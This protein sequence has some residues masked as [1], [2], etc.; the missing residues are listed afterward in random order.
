MDENVSVPLRSFPSNSQAPLSSPSSL[1]PSLPLCDPPTTPISILP[2]YVGRWFGSFI[3]VLVRVARSPP[4]AALLC[5]GCPAPVPRRF[6][7]PAIGHCVHLALIFVLDY[8]LNNP[9]TLTKYKTAAQISEKVLADVSKL[10]VA[11]AKIVDLCEQGDKLIEEELAKV[12]RG[13]K[14]TKGV[15]YLGSCRNR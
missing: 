5:P 9:D 6:P 8:S 1:F 2:V 11:G 3:Q 14:I 15:L 4:C 12:Y 13:K 7:I 10:C